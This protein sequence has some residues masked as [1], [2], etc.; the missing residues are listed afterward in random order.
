MNTP[1]PSSLTSA[2]V[3]GFKVLLYG[4]SGTGKTYSIRTLVDAGLKPFVLFTE[5]GMTTLRDT[6]VEDVKWFYVPP[7]PF[8]VE[9]FTKMLDN[10]NTLPF[11]ALTALKDPNKTDYKQMLHISNA[12]ANFRDDRTGEVYGC[13]DTWSHDRV[14]VVDS[15]SGIVAAAQGLT[16]GGRP[17][18]AQNDYGTVMNAVEKFLNMLCLGTRANVVMIAHE[19]REVDEV[20]GGTKVMPSTIGRKLSPKLGR[21]FDDVILAE[22]DLKGNF[23]WTTSK[24]NYELKSRHL[25]LKAGLEPSFVPLVQS[26]RR[27][28]GAQ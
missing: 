28:A 7:V 13:V 21:F 25:P 10:I 11:E 18:M 24:P 8:N 12:L 6:K 19:E 20:A 5:N 2:P 27:V 15:L 9:S 3:S 4:G 14:F 22:K 16:V 26:W 17:T 1:V 23:T